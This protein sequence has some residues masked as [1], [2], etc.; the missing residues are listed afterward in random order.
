[1]MTSLKGEMVLKET[2]PP[3]SKAL[4]EKA[5]RVARDVVGPLA[6]TW[7]RE[8]RFP[9]ELFQALR[10]ERLNA[11]TAPR[12][13]GGQ[14]I[15]PDTDNPLPVWLV[16]KALATM[17]SSSSHCQQ[18]HTNMVHT[19]A[20][21]GTPEQKERYLRPAAEGGAVFGGW[22]S[23]Q[24]GRPP[25]PGARRTIARKVKGGYE[26]TGKKYYSTN[27]GGAKYAIVFGYLEDAPDPV[28]GLL[29]CAVDC[30]SRGVTV[31][32]A[33]W[34]QA[35]GMRATVSHE[36]DLDRV[37]V[38]DDAIIGPPG[39]YWTQKMQ[40]RYLPQFSAN[41]QGVGAHVFSYGVTYLRERNRT[42]NEFIQRYLGEARICLETA[43][44]L[45]GET[46]ERYKERRYPEAFHYSSMLRAY[47]E[48]S[49]RRVVDLVQSACGASVYMRPN[50]MERILRDWQFY[51]RHENSDLILTAVGKTELGV[52]S[53]G[54]EAFGFAR[55]L[56]GAR[57]I[58]LID[59]EAKG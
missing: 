54:A 30:E 29:L 15:G 27:A 55:D 40:A 25:E 34:D 3:Q 10:K 1:M 28:S 44:L 4:V 46:A 20:Q 16:T 8:N 14:G 53:E 45:L 5:E 21:L 41:F 37:F 6:E 18:V 12:E 19:V 32:K 48:L 38:S 7:D 51:C 33:W 22:G 39:A 47:S 59:R 31:N 56:G 36:V 57:S 49:I 9:A 26:L 11:M 52:A 17:D 24:D 23:E 58:S 50:P 35:T 43:E 42:K 2:L 13:Y